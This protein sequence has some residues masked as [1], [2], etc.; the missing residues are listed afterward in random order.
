MKYRTVLYCIVQNSIASAQQEQ[1]KAPIV[2]GVRFDRDGQ[3]SETFSL[4]L[5]P[6][7]PSKVRLRFIEYLKQF[8][9]WQYE[10]ATFLKGNGF[11]QSRNNER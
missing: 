4:P 2:D 7:I 5:F 10:L 6:V 11:L 3:V 1:A 9:A 8:A